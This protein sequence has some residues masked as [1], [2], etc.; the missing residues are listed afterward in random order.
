MSKDKRIENF[1][2]VQY[3]ETASKLIN[4]NYLTE[5]FSDYPVIF[6]KI[7]DVVKRVT[8]HLGGSG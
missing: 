2:P 1:Y 6:D 5:Q 3:E 8:S 4:H 7:L